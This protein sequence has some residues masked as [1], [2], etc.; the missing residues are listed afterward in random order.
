MK[1]KEKRQRDNMLKEETDKGKV[2]AADRMGVKTTHDALEK[3][4]R[5]ERKAEKRREIIED[6]D[7]GR[8]R[9]NGGVR[10]YWKRKK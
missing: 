1:S 8:L 4:D 5:N 7:R 6:N 9:G 3:C 2:K 10:K